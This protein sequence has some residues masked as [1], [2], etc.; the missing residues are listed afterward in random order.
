MNGEKHPGPNSRRHFLKAL[1]VG[2]GGSMLAGCDEP[3]APD[4]A[5]DTSKLIAHSSDSFEGR[6]E[7]MQSFLTPVD[8]FFVRKNGKVPNVNA[9]QYRLEVT[10]G[11]LTNPLSLSLDDLMALPSRTVFSYLECAGN[12]RSFFSRLLGQT[13][14]GT[15][16][17]RGAI[18]MAS[19]TGTP[20]AEVLRAA[21]TADS[22]THIQLVGLDDSAPEGGFRRPIPIDKAMDPDTLLAYRMNGA[23]LLPDHGFPIRAI[24][25]GWVGSS[26]IKW[27]GRL[28]VGTT[29]VWSRNNTTSYVLIGDAYPPE[30]EA[31]G[32]VITE[33]SIK[34]ALALPWPAQMRAGRQLIYGYA[35]SPNGFIEQVRWS[36]DN[37]RTW[38]EATVLSPR[39]RYA[40]ARFEIA[41]DAPVGEHTIMT[42]AK[43]ASGVEQPAEILFNQKG[44]LF[45][46]HL[47]HPI[48][49]EA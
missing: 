30:G 39:M 19:W 5:K 4:L 11:A 16:W 49:V 41:W 43:D 7:D 34:S 31:L 26:S 48:T 17:G 47:P 28:E 42:S 35:H 46:M 13:A 25:P 22:A 36:T 2:A 3:S 37:G 8:Q 38:Q 44:Y 40:W 29:E 1:A 14:A 6:L 21:G 15:Q 32:Q 33:Q 20:L 18:G 12:Q 9:V 45:N 27:L 23:P 10:G 24:V